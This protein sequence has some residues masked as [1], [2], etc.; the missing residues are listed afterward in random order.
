MA[1]LDIPFSNSEHRL[2]SAQKRLGPLRGA[3]P[4]YG[5]ADDFLAEP[6]R[7]ARAAEV[8][9]FTFPISQARVENQNT[10]PQES[11]SRPLVLGRVPPALPSSHTSATPMLPPTGT[12]K[13]RGRVVKLAGVIPRP[14]TPEPRLTRDGT[15]VLECPVPKHL[16]GFVQYNKRVVDMER[17]LGAHFSA[18]NKKYLCVGCPVRLLDQDFFRALPE[19]LAKIRVVGEET[20]VGG[21]GMAF[22]RKDSMMRHVRGSP[23]LTREPIESNGARG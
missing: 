14:P 16:C 20:Y 13:G 18:A 23:C 2:Q 11:T 17:H 12:T 8:A 7:V 21:C 19:G 4:G 10:V 9:D 5:L 15:W 6:R 1:P 22:D 3:P